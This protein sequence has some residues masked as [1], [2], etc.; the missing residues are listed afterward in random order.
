MAGFTR[1]MDFHDRYC[2]GCDPTCGIPLTAYPGSTGNAWRTT[3]SQ[4]ALGKNY[5]SFK[6]VL[7]I[8]CLVLYERPASKTTGQAAFPPGA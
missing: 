6:L 1:S 3:S 5:R 7:Q 4:R 8:S 2:P